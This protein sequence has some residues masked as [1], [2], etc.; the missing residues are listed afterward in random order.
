MDLGIFILYIREES[1]W[2]ITC[3]LQFPTKQWDIKRR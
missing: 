2:K 3:E 1:R